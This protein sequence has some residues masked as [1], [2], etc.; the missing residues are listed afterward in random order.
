MDFPTLLSLPGLNG[1]RLF[2]TLNLA[3]HRAGEGKLINCAHNGTGVTGL[4]ALEG[5]KTL[6][7]PEL[8]RICSV[9]P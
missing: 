1:S 5:A 2:K 6:P 9:S 4:V 7:V 3:L 8:A